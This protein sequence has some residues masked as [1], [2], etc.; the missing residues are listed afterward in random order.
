MCFL[1]IYALV[2][3]TMVIVKILGKGGDDIISQVLFKEILTAPFINRKYSTLC[4]RQFQVT[5]ML[6][7]DLAFQAKFL[8]GK[9]N[10]FE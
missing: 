6:M 8:T 5:K 1:D 9:S 2:A 7:K 4:L 3:G 10:D